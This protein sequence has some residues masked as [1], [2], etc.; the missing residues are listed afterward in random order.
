M[1]EYT[2]S[3]AQLNSIGIWSNF[4]TF[5]FLRDIK[6]GKIINLIRWAGEHWGLKTYLMML[7]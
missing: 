1:P 6:V 3:P 7:C 5:L 4:I 2:H